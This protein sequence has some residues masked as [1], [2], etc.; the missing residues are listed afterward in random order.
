M[1]KIPRDLSGREFIGLLSKF[2]YQVTRQSG[3]HIRITSSYMN[4]VH[5]ITFPDHHPLKSG[6]LNSI[7]KEIAEYLK[8]SRDAI[9]DKLF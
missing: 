9:I 6:T 4:Q 5:H 8:I 2:G 7:L 1:H 3:C